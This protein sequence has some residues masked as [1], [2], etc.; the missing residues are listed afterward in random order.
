MYIVLLLGPLIG[1]LI[2]LALRVQHDITLPYC[3]TCWRSFKTA[4]FLEAMSLL[5]FFAAIVLGVVLMLKLN[6][7]IAFYIPMI[8]SVVLI[9]AAQRYKRRFHP[10]YKK[11]NRKE[12]VVLAGPYGE[13]V[14]SKVTTAVA[15][16]SSQ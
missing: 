6:S 11:V 2:L 13:I 15:R 3:K 9:V 8:V 5:S 14:F 1:L 4:N 7:G 16:P 12:A 10:K